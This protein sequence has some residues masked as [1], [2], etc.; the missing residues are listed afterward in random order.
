M[1]DKP[2]IELLEFEVFARVGVHGR[3]LAGEQE[4]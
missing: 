3:P 4:E 2:L 1:T